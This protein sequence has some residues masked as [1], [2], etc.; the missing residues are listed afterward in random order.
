[1][2]VYASEGVAFSAAGR[3]LNF[4][5]VFR[6]RSQKEYEAEIYREPKPFIR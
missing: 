3:S 5:E 6:P 2:F 1:M 4:V